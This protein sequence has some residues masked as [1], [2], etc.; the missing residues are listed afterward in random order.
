MI[1][2]DLK[3]Q[4]LELLKTKKRKT[5]PLYKLKHMITFLFL[6]NEFTEQTNLFLMLIGLLVLCKVCIY[7]R[8]QLLE[9]PIKTQLKEKVCKTLF[10][11]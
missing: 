6:M 7:L 5:I 3:R 9:E 1:V 4:Q 10:L 11:V 2:Q 8:Q